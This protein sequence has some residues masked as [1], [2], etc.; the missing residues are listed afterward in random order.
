MKIYVKDITQK[1]LKHLYLE[2]FEFHLLV[3]FMNT[4]EN[5]QHIYAFITIYYI[6]QHY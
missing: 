2:H 5:L 6:Q 1:V 3:T 4:R